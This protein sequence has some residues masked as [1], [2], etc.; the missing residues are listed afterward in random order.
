VDE[1]NRKPQDKQ[2]KRVRSQAEQSL[3]VSV[4]LRACFADL[5][6]DSSRSYPLSVCPCGAWLQC[7]LSRCFGMVR[8][9]CAT[10]RLP[11]RQWRHRHEDGVAAG[12]RAG[13]RRRRRRAARRAWVGPRSG[14]F[15]SLVLRLQFVPL[16]TL[17]RTRS[18]GVGG[19]RAEGACEL[20]DARCTLPS[21][22]QT[23]HRSNSRHAR[24]L[25]PTG[26]LHPAYSA[27]KKEARRRRSKP[28]EPPRKHRAEQRKRE[29]SAASTCAW[30]GRKHA[31]R[32]MRVW[33]MAHTYS[34]V[35]CA[36]SPAP[37]SLLSLWRGLS[38]LSFFCSCV[39]RR[40]PV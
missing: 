4:T 9:S 23:L 33:T 10:T 7:F 40:C 21:R 12:G 6:I 1:R 38:P 34:Q 36:R 17:V 13:G 30:G 3:R 27:F 28:K 26:P 18:L 32:R 31:A 29:E 39:C 22:T 15:V 5:S 35:R 11:L 16:E 19:G 37:A 25:T 24:S 2:R 8:R 14:L 20:S